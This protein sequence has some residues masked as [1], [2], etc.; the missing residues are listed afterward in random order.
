MS[1]PP[2][3]QSGLVA[4]PAELLPWDT[5]FFGFPIARVCGDVLT[6]ESAAALD[7]WCRRGGVRCLYLQCR[8]DDPQSPPLAEALGYQLVDVR[9]TFARA[10]EGTAPGE[11]SPMIR[12]VGPED[13][14][15]LRQLAATAH[16]DTRFYFD[17]HFP[18][19][20]CDALYAQWIQASCHGYADAVLVAGPPGQPVGYVTCHLDSAAGGAHEGRIGLIAVAE[21]ARGRGLGSQ[22]VREALRWF[23]GQGAASV[24]VVTQGR[25]VAAQRLYQ[26]CGFLTRDVHLV[27]HKWYE[28]FPQSAPTS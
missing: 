25:N 14:T 18:R 2:P 23:A 27:Y 28:P 10:A 24:S 6:P 12:L 21:V 11:R 1:D 8:C 26:R 16:R 4:G 3:V 5:Q 20:Q 22:L 17:A 9:M 7:E 19:P 13:V 15:A